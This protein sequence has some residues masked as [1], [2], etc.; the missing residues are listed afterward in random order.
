MIRFPECRDI[1]HL[2]FYADCGAARGFRHCLFPASHFTNTS[3]FLSVLL[4]GL[5]SQY[6]TTTSDLYSFN[7]LI[8]SSW[9]KGSAVGIAT[10]YG[11]GARGVGV[12]VLVEARFFSSRQ[13]FWG[14]PNGYQGLSPGVK[15][16]RREV[17]HSPPANAEVKNLCIYTPMCVHGIVFN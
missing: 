1:Y 8:P 12:E 9:S 10:G 13:Q 16:P 6:H 3:L 5:T 2:G 14:P 15:W 11:L 7:F 17:D 4:F